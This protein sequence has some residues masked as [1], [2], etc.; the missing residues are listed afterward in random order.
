M[1]KE[2]KKAKFFFSSELNQKKFDVIENKAMKIKDFKNEVSKEI[3]FNL[4]NFLDKTKYDVIKKF[5][6]KINDLNGQNIQNAISDVWVSYSNMF[7][8]IKKE[9]SFKKKK[10]K[11]IKRKSPKLQM[12]LSFLSKYGYIG[13][14]N[15]LKIPIH[16]KKKAIFYQEIKD[17]CQKYGEDR[18]LNLALA[19]RSR[20]I[21]KKSKLIQFNQLSFR[22][23]TR[24]NSNIFDFNKNFLSKFNGYINLGGY[25]DYKK[26]SIP[27]KFNKEYHGNK[28]NYHRDLSKKQNSQ[29]YQI[30]IINSKKKL[31]RITYLI[32]DFVEIQENNHSYLGVDTNVKRNLFSTEL[33]E[34][35]FDRNMINNYVKFLQKIDNRKSKKLN[36]KRRKS[37]RKWRLKI[38]NQIKEKMSDLIK[39]A[40][41]NNRNHLILEDLSLLGK[42]RIP[43]QFG[44]NYGRLFRLLGLTSIKNELENMCRNQNISI[45][46]V[47]PEFSS[48]TCYVCGNISKENRKNQ[49]EFICVSCGNSD[50]ADI[51]SSKNLQYRLLSNV[52]RELLLD[53]NE[54][55][56][57]R[58]KAYIPMGLIRSSISNSYS[59]EM[60]E[61]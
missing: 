2:I 50:D 52:L 40:K 37:Y 6:C 16:D 45:S 13:I 60:I 7:D 35:D 56:E 9:L 32:D 57:W 46:F 4:I 28:S 58:P 24:I 21:K 8:S 3:H 41:K 33:G 61:T 12:I 34:I 55:N 49:S 14:S 15:D 30:K 26:L 31:I 27:T 5:N 19:R 20:I 48:Q 22:T 18:L 25:S 53:Q 39:F 36:K 29:S 10:S 59:S 1:I 44:I 11:K 17:Y 23:I 51:N 42:L 43:S 38:K 47:Q 54:F